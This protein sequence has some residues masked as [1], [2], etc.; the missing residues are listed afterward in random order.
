MSKPRDIRDMSPDERLRCILE[1]YEP[2]E[3]HVWVTRTAVINQGMCNCCQKK[4]E[5]TVCRYC[6]QDKH[7]LDTMKRQ[8]IQEEAASR[9]PMPDFRIGGCHGR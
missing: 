5:I 1:N 4:R 7:M 9:M 8:L 6:G 3:D 2:C